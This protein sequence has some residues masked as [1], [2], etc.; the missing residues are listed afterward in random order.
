MNLDTM[1]DKLLWLNK[2]LQYYN[3]INED[4]KKKIQS[5][6]LNPNGA[7]KKSRLRKK[8][9]NKMLKLIIKK[10]HTIDLIILKNLSK[11]FESSSFIRVY[12][13]QL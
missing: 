5:K 6:N 1:I 10:N 9:Q 4:V 7:K 12:Y 11:P 13:D 2:L 8:I 3:I